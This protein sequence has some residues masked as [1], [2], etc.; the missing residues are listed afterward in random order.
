M[1]PFGAGVEGWVRVARSLIDFNPGLPVAWHS[2]VT[3]FGRR[4]MNDLY[5]LVTKREID[6]DG[7][8]CYPPAWLAAEAVTA[9]EALR[10]MT[11]NGAHALF[12]EDHIGSLRRGKFADVIIL[13][14]NPLTMDPG[15][16]V[17]ID[18]LMTMVGG[19]VEHCLP[20]YERG[21]VLPRTST[22]AT[23][24]RQAHGTVEGQADRD[25]RAWDTR[26][27]ACPWGRHTLWRVH[28]PRRPACRA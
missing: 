22:Q 24:G 23:S 1:H 8:V 16:I 2:D 28:L 13:S 19:E 5:E 25:Q 18:V 9:E 12:M 17:D 4:P 7:N 14:E 20:E 6:A 11:I 3:G 27:S 10:M 21:S 26:G 15:R